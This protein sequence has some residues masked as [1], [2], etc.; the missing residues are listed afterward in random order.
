[1]AKAQPIRITTA[2]RS[3]AEDIAIRQKRYAISMSIRSLCFIGA[4]IAGLAGIGWLWPILIAG[5]LVLPYLAVV[6]ANAAN[7]K[8]DEMNLID[9]PYGR[10]QL[11]SGREQHELHE[12]GEL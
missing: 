3:R 4:V 8:S 9:S 1:M 7:T 5:A 6:M 2:G 12:K 10:P 11:T